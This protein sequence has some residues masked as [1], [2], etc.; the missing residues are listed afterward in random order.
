MLDVMSTVIEVSHQTIPMSGGGR[1]KTEDPN[2]LCPFEQTIPGWSTEVEPYK[3]DAVFWHA[4]WQSAGRPTR[5]PLKE[6]MAKTRNQYHYA[7]RRVKKMAESIRS[8]KL[9]EA[10]ELGSV[11]LL[12][13]IKKIK[14]EKKS[15]ESLPDMVAGV[16]G[17][18][19]IAEEFR[20]VYE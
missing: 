4:V 6:M 15:S 9:L 16:S 11:N 14:V 5:G 12:M 8:K 13:E 19:L 10:S 18:S 3:K 2:K 7:V 20:K 1:T 17:E